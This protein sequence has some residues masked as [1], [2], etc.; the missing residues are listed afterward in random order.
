MSSHTDTTRQNTVGAYASASCDT[1]TAGNRGKGTDHDV[2]SDMYLIIDD[3]TLMYHRI[4]QRATINRRI[5]TNV[6]IVVNYHT[7]N[8]GNLFPASSVIGKT[9]AI[10]TNHR[11]RMDID[12]ITQDTIVI[13]H[14]I[15]S[16]ATVSPDTDARLK[17]CS[18]FDDGARSN[19]HIITNYR[20]RPHGHTW[21]NLRR[22][23][24]HCR[25]MN[26]CSRTWRPVKESGYFGICQIGIC[27]HQRITGKPFRVSRPQQY[28]TRMGLQQLTCIARKG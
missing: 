10:T 5:R 1:H 3:H 11:T 8:L 27:Q 21:L 18:G 28:S 6:Y 25:R 19:D 23:T 12:P 16:D 17:H 26:F 2:M 24:N 14:R 4:I 9:K 13:N 15:G 22:L 7:A 20:T